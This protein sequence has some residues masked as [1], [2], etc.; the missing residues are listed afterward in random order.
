MPMTLMEDIMDTTIEERIEE[1]EQRQTRFVLAST[2]TDGWINYIQSKL[3]EE[4]EFEHALISQA[5]A[6]LQRDFE[7]I[8][9]RV[10]SETMEKRIRGTYSESEKYSAGDL[11]AKDGASFVARKDSPGK[12]PNSGD[13]QLVAKQGSRGIAGPR[14]EPA[15]RISGWKLDPD[16]FTATPIMSD[17]S[18]CPPLELRSLFEQYNAETT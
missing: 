9:K 6:T 10:V 11:V 4:R 18:Y 14:G 12:C 1:I 7:A 15:G 3:L 16:A 17:G 13:W 2:G 5:V 8:A